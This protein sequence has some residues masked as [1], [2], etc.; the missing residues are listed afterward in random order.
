MSGNLL[1]TGVAGFIGRQV[2]EQ[3]IAR[4]Y[5]VTGLDRRASP[6]RGIHVV[7]AD[8]RDRDRLM[9]VARNQDSIIHLAAMTSNVQFV[10]NP[11]ECYDVNTNGFLSVI[12]AA[13]RGGCQRFVYASSAAVY[14]EG[15]SEEA[16]IDP[17]AQDNH[18][19]KSK[20]M[21]EMTAESYKRIHGLS[22]IGL[23]YFNVYGDGEN[24]K[25]DYASIVTLFLR[26]KRNH[27]SLVVYGD[28]AQARDL[29]HVTNAA[30]LTLDLLEKGSHDV[31]N[32]GTGVATTYRAIA[33]M[34]DRH[35]IRYVANP[36][37][38]YQQYTRAETTRLHETLGVY[39]LIELKQG[40]R[41]LEAEGGRSNP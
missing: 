12:D 34:I 26:A 21:N 2:A 24:A 22:T 1:I 31:Y 35:H 36:L 14:L 3:A 39:D 20:I 29:I 16:V 9:T 6:V 23:R 19:A 13:A 18:Y 40:I 38:N 17:R 27:D 28:G 37:P 11:A 25:G 4:G 15:F 41:D 33:E 7:Q 30:R 10:K 32:V 5:R 8:I